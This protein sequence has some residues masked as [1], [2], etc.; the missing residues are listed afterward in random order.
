MLEAISLT[1]AP[2]PIL[3]MDVCLTVS[4][5]LKVSDCL[6]GSGNPSGV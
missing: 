6:T 1:D 3:G 2:G 5:C 4:D